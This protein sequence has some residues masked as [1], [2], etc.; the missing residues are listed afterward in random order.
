[1][2]PFLNFL[3]K[4]NLID[5]GFRGPKFTWTN[6]RE[7]CS[8]IRTRIGRSH[9]NVTWLNLFP[10]SQ[11]THL[12]RLSSDHWPILLQTHKITMTGQKPFRF[13]PFWMKHP[14]FLDLTSR[15]WLSQHGNLSQ[16]VT[17][18]QKELSIWNKDNFGNI[19]HEIKRTKARLYGLQKIIHFKRDSQLLLLEQTL[20]DKIKTLLEY[21]ESIWCMK[22]RINWLSLG[23]KNTTFFHMSTVLNRRFNKILRL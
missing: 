22:S 16:I 8:L 1:M 3:K 4:A 20:Q 18:F 14:S 19:F 15:V 17:D 11:V 13:E 21:E 6:C 23:D 5:L 12:P 10:D 9:A 2:Q 7:S